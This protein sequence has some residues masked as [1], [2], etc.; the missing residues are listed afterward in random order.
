MPAQTAAKTAKDSPMRTGQPITPETVKLITSHETH[1]AG[2]YQATSKNSQMPHVSA[3]STKHIENY[4]EPTSALPVLLPKI[5]CID[6]FCLNSNTEP[7][8][9]SP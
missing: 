4:A 5:D 7:N 6:D 9:K 1:F 2:Y 8:R 3:Q